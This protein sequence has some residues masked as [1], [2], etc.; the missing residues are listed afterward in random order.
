MSTEIW[1]GTQQSLDSF[2]Q[3]LTKGIAYEY[4]LITWSGPV[5]DHILKKMTI[6]C[7]EHNILNIL[8]LQY[9][10]S[11]LAL[12]LMLESKGNGIH[13]KIA[14]FPHHV[15]RSTKFRSLKVISISNNEIEKLRRR[16]SLSTV[17]RHILHHQQR[18]LYSHYIKTALSFSKFNHLD[19]KQCLVLNSTTEEEMRS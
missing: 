15:I 14:S 4:I 13:L 7:L 9:P 6:T 1:S 5:S 3:N 19:T 17:Q 8:G 12:V 18:L 10:S 2:T 11:H 16:L